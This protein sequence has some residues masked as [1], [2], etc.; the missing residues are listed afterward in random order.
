MRMRI[1]T[2]VF[3][4]TIATTSFATTATVFSP[5]VNEGDRSFEYRMSYIPEDTP[6]PDIFSQRLHFQ[7]AFD[8]ALRARLVANHRSIDGRSLDYR[9]T[10]LE[11]Q[12]QYR[13]NEVH[14]WDAALRFDAEIGDESPDRIRLVWTAQ[15]N[16]GA[17]WQ[18]RGN[19]LVGREFGSNGASGVTLET[20]AQVTKRIGSGKRLGL[21]LFSDL[22]STGN[23]GHYS[24]QE[25]KL[26]PIFKADIGSKWTLNAGYL[27]GISDAADNGDWRL[28]FVHRL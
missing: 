13:E 26:G 12:W 11:V 28:M 15:R 18:L 4:L 2:P 20:R 14:D 7:Y 16:F 22:N 19:A 6:V 23:V 8:G 21:E 5:D 10:R 24:D 25:H 3:L 17:G 1:L 9:S 27:F